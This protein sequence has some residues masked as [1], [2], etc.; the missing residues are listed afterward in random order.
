[1]TPSA[2]PTLYL[3]ERSEIA[4]ESEA[5]FQRIVEH[6]PGVVF[7]YVVDPQGAPSFTYVSPNT[8]AVYGL[9]ADELQK[10]PQYALD[11]VHPDD[12]ARLDSI[13]SE[14]LDTMTPCQWEGRL[15]GHDGVVRWVHATGNP[16]RH[17]DGSYGW[18]GMVLDITSW[19]DAELRARELEHRRAEDAAAAEATE[20]H[21]THVIQSVTEGFA[22]VDNEWRVTFINR[23][24]MQ[25][26]HTPPGYLL[27]R[28]IWDEFPDAFGTRFETEFKR[29]K[30]ENV[31]VTFVE[32]FAP[33]EGWFEMR[34]FP[35]P[36]G[37]SFY[38]RDVT[39]LREAEMSLKLA[40]S[41]AEKANAAKDEYLTRISQELRNPLNAILGFAALL[42]AHV[43][44]PK[45][46]E[47]CEQILLAGN[48]LTRIL[49]DIGEFARIES[50]ETSLSL[51]PVSVTAVVQEVLARVLDDAD[52]R[53]VSV[54]A[55]SV[56]QSPAIVW[57]DFQR[58]LQVLLNLVAN[59]I[60]FN[61]SG[62][63]VTITCESQSVQRLRLSVVDTGPGLTPEQIE[64]LWIPFE[65]LDAETLEYDHGGAGVGLALARGLTRRMG[66]NIGCDSK[67]GSGSRFWIE[68]PA[69]SAV[70][71]PYVE[72][73][74]H[75]SDGTEPSNVRFTV[76]YVEDNWSNYRL[77]ERIFEQRP[78]ITLYL[79]NQGMA[80]L[81]LAHRHRPNL[82]LLDIHLPDMQGADLLRHLRDQGLGDIPVVIVT[83]DTKHMRAREMMAL[84]AKAYLV[85][86]IQ[87]VEFL[88]VVDAI[89]EGRDIATK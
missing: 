59:A 37:M 50:G 75:M 29:S 41:A 51:E 44:Q 35:S 2:E 38:F 12:R 16:F 53:E 82:I 17:D 69:Y 89:L 61:A 22:T 23:M 47:Y 14:S 15:I 40:K 21:L 48:H 73:T 10:H 36:E 74:P 30:E 80:A 24:G 3:A 4:Q 87:I 45:S 56:L 43:S 67:P 18:D 79:A 1:M 63:S 57:A 34:A 25:L 64:R 31:A 32:Y 62:G 77:M 83:G 55:T 9:A 76:L 58:L 85:K 60:Q 42:R 19:R 39:A 26:T 78:H 66:G 65:R 5:Q 7:Q 33:L 27:G 6:A 81:N 49:A 54:N 28:S 84:G 11:A 86:P 46:R 13:M 88:N 70:A 8:K 72:T 52:A 68:L 71:P 20:R